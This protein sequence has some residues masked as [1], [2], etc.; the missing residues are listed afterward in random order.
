MAFNLNSNPTTWV[1][2][3]VSNNQ[4]VPLTNRYI[5]TP[6]GTVVG[7]ASGNQTYSTTAPQGPSLTQKTVTTNTSGGSS[8]NNVSAPS[9]PSMDTNAELA[10]RQAEIDSVFNP[11][12]SYLGQAESNLRNDLPSALAEAES[13]FKTS[14]ALLGNKKSQAQRELGTQETAAGTRK[15]DALTSARRTYNE[16][17]QGGR[18]RFG[19][20]SSAGQ[21]FSELSNRE[22]MRNQGGIESSFQTAMNQIGEQKL[23]VEEDYNSGLMQLEQQKQ[24]SINQV[25]R[26]FQNKLLE[27][28][29]MRAEAESNKAQMR[30]QALQDLRNQVF[31][32]Q[33]QNQQFAQQLALQKANS[34]TSL[35]AYAKQLA[36]SI[37]AGTTAT[38]TMADTVSGYTGTNL[39]VTPNSPAIAS[40][41]LTGSTTGRRPE[42]ELGLVA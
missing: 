32:I 29:R 7:Q 16:L 15:E 36:D 18:Q 2:T 39:G 33:L 12:F 34:S 23:K 24:Q 26:D 28:S 41:N 25:N 35:D 17:Q 8:S 19:G 5:A 31:S 38:K 4:N 14:S 22:L 40:L 10:A 21:A 42:D 20:A 27:I 30:L 3:P 6:S 9:A 1:Q 37:G 13:Q 11:Q